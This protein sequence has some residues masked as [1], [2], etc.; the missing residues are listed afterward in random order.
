[1]PYKLN[2]FF[3]KII[4]E[5]ED[6]TITTFYGSPGSG[7]STLCFQYTAEVIKEGKK[8]IF[9]DTEGGFSPNR[10]L[11]IDPNC[12][13]SNILVYSPKS[14]SQQHKTIISLNKEIK[15]TNQIGLIV[16]DSLVM[17]YRLKLG[18]APQ[19][20]NKELGEQL[21]ML[22]ELS[23]TYSIPVIA[24]NQMYKSFD[25]KESKMVGGLTIEYWSKTIVELNYE[26]SIRTLKLIKHKSKKEGE[27][28]EFEIDN[29]GIKEKL[30]NNY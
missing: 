28:K 24:T 12:N 5:L 16:I 3:D 2:S 21:R 8:V 15:N 25:T 20:I 9:I 1:M 29:K 22:T 27:E 14:F 30:A 6:K 7:K 4:G 26:N 11:Q 19:K 10:I 18:S 17:L 23:R 13:L